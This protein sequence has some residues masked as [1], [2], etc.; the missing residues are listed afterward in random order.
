[1]ATCPMRPGVVSMAGPYARARRRGSRSAE[2]TGPRRSAGGGPGRGEGEDL[3]GDGAGG[4]VGARDP[5]RRHEELAGD[6]ATGEAEGP[7]EELH[8]LV[9]GAGVVGA[10]PAV[11]AAV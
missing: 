8:P 10:Q 9:L 3:G 11:E 6:L 4:V 2:P 5:A 7:L 1:M